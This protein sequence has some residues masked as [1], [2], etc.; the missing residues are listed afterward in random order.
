MV[1]K[2]IAYTMLVLLCVFIILTMITQTPFFRDWLKAQIVSAVDSQTEAALSIGS[3]SGNLLTTIIMS[4]VALSREDDA[5]IQ[6]ESL[7]VRYR[8]LRLLDRD[9]WIRSIELRNPRVTLSKRGDGT[10]NVASLFTADSAE[11]MEADTTKSGWTVRVRSFRITSGQVQ[12][13]GLTSSQVRIPKRVE[14][15]DLNAFFEYRDGMVALDLRDAAFRTRD[16]D[17]DVSDLK[18]TLRIDSNRVV[19]RNTALRM[20]RTVLNSDLEIEDLDDP[21]LDLRFEGRGIV[22]SDIRRFVPG[23]QLR[24]NYQVT[25]N[26]TGATDD[27][28]I[29]LAVVNGGGHIA[30]NGVLNV[31]DRPIRYRLNG[32]LSGINVKNWINESQIHSDIN[33]SIELNG[34]NS[35]WGEI[36]A[37]LWVD[38]ERSVIETYQVDSLSLTGR[39]DRDNI[40]FDGSVF[41]YGASAQVD[42]AMVLSADRS[43]Y[44]MNGSFA[45]ID[46]S[47]LLNDPSI[48]SDLNFD[49]SVSSPDSGSGYAYNIRLRESVVEQTPID[50][51]LIRGIWADESLAVDDLHFV[52]PY[53]KIR[54]AG[55]LD[56]TG[57]GRISFDADITDAAE[58]TRMILP[59]MIEGNGSISGAISGR[60][61]SIRMHATFDF[62][63]LGVDEIAFNALNGRLTAGFDRHGR[64]LEI[65]SRSGDLDI[66]GYRNQSS[67]ISASYIDTLI[68]YD[69]HVQVADSIAMNTGGRLTFTSDG[70]HIDMSAL[71]VLAYGQDWRKSERGIR[72]GYT[73]NRIELDSLELISADGLVRVSGDISLAPA[74]EIKDE[75]ESRI[76]VRD[77][78]DVRLFAKN[79]DLSVL[80]PFT[81]N[82]SGIEGTL[83][84][85]IRIFNTLDDMKGQGPVRIKNGELAIPDIGTTYSDIR[86]LVMLNDNEIIIQ[87]FQMNSGKG[88]LQ[89]V[90]GSLS[91][92]KQSLDEFEA[93]LRARNF[94]AM[95]TK[96]MRAVVN[97]QI[98]LSGSID[99]LQFEGD[100]T[101]PEA[102]I[103]YSDWISEEKVVALKTQPFFIIGSDSVKFDPRG[104]RRY[105]KNQTELRAPSS[106]SKFYKN[107]KANVSLKFPR[108]TWIR[109]HEVNVEVQGE[110]D[111]IK[112]GMDLTLFGTLNAVRGYYELQGKRF[113]IEQGRI[114]FKGN[115]Q[116]NPDI[117][118]K[119]VHEFREQVE[120]ADKKRT[121]AVVLSGTAQEPR[122]QFS[123]DDVEAEQKDIL[124]IL[125]FGRSF[126]NLPIGQRNDMAAETSLTDQ[127]TG[128]MTK[129]L[130]RQFTSRIG[131][132]LNLDVLQIES[133]QELEET[134]LKI[135]KYITPDVYI[136][137]SQD[138]AAEG[139][140]K[141]ELEYKIPQRILLLNLFL[142]AL[143]E[144]E[145][146]T[147]MDVIWKVEW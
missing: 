88:D 59:D 5:V 73:E 4:N 51:A 84:S 28:S 24:G 82:I 102:R 105:Q 27:L 141:I 137:V 117:D 18:T 118:I 97:G 78:L 19:A 79:L 7:A 71:R 144:R 138:F 69:V 116:I 119:A 65:D 15:I 57:D 142:Q 100:L 121:M 13:S 1:K 114:S 128:F 112:K 62:S 94:M 126:N 9:I 14:D 72:L 83:D 8:P 58:L 139:N 89:T 44:Q 33:L 41:A 113:Q 143:K 67:Q 123:V 77:S 25:L 12:L 130:I 42:A 96:R 107:L 36:L 134:R 38:A 91:L 115:P 2:V 131:N 32:S 120:G 110:L 35:V 122:F 54:A 104:A 55:A 87:Q 133:G 70:F 98:D 50:T 124:S 45:N 30:L 20:G 10:W 43:A 75:D 85:D 40:R 125:L 108:N 63:R 86:L 17:L 34:E 29:D 61:D 31:K 111:L 37:D 145:G 129:Q 76:D 11:N 53:A 92:S 140:Q 136:V 49:A 135:G 64:L 3:I 22:M 109:G 127:A 23:L 66:Y 93:T 74:L 56:S 103:N 26:A 81:A 52:T 21:E 101:I 6:L 147:A 47:R 106:E 16:P 46:L 99:A 48:K 146:E 95:N 80:Q 90:K 39:I 68:D 60:P 132:Q